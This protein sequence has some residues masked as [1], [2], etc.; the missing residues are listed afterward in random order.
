MDLAQHY[1]TTGSLPSFLRKQ[2]SRKTFP[3]KR[4]SS[5]R[6]PLSRGKFLDSR[7][8]GNDVGVAMAHIFAE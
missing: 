6:S 3:R 8:H 5:A 7:L 2:E 4:E 1:V